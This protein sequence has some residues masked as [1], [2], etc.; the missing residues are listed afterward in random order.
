MAKPKIALFPGSFDPFHQGHLGILKQ[1]IPL[2]DKIY[3]VIT[4][5]INKPT[6][7]KLSVLIAAVKKAT[8]DLCSVEII[9]NPRPVLTSVIAQKYQ[10]QYLIRG[11]RNN[12]DACYER[13]LAIGNNTLQRNL[14]TICFFDYSTDQKLSSSLL[15]EIKALKKP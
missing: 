12:R 9:T 1:A 15:R 13:E 5:N 14:M 11:I 4:N 2:F 6:Q 10:A 7:S 8:Q 3:I